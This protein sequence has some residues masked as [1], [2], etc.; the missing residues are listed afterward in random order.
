MQPLSLWL[1]LRRNRC[2]S[3]S[4]Q[5]NHVRTRRS[6]C[7]R[8]F[9]LKSLFSRRRRF[10]DAVRAMGALQE[11]ECFCQ[12]TNLCKHARRF[13][14]LCN[15]SLTFRENKATTRWKQSGSSL[16]LMKALGHS[17]TL[18]GSV[19]GRE[20]PNW[21]QADRWILQVFFF[22][23]RVVD[24]GRA[25]I[26]NTRRSHVGLMRKQYANRNFTKSTQKIVSS[27]HHHP[28]CQDHLFFPQPVL[29]Y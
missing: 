9:T 15:M 2:F 4:M 10:T 7:L 24:S 26:P 21:T 19:K 28:I 29:A 22:W 20:K 12:A 11:A 1:L 5:T 18:H 8:F 16:L 23:L 13:P 6:Q 17:F 3:A 14:S 25:R 27:H